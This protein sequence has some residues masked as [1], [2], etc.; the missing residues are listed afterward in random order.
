[1]RLLGQGGNDRFTVRFDQGNP[2]PAH[3][4]SVSGG[5]GFDRLFVIATAGNDLVNLT[6]AQVLV[7]G[8]A[9][10][11][12]SLEQMGIHG[13]AGADVFNALSVNY[14]AALVLVRFFGEGGNDTALLTPSATTQFYIDGGPP[15]RPAFPGDSLAFAFQG[16]A[17]RPPVLLSN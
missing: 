14:Q 10:G 17:V 2:V 16:A 3:D 12:T 4:L 1:V 11:Y 8:A 6:P 15:A 9:I 13:G 5:T 7:N